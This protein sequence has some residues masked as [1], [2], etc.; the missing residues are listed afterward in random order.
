MHRFSVYERKC[1]RR[2]LSSQQQTAGSSLVQEQIAGFRSADGSCK[3]L[4]GHEYDDMDIWL[5]I[6]LSDSDASYRTVTSAALRAIFVSHL[7]LYWQ[8]M[9]VEL[10]SSGK[11]VCFSQKVFRIALTY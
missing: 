11:G 8:I 10:S 5:H 9:L 6:I 4:R 2:A 1:M 7:A 3:T